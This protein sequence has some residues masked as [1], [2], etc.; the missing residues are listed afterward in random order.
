MGGANQCLTPAA[1]ARAAPPRSPA[2]GAGRAIED[3]ACRTA[4]CAKDTHNGNQGRKGS[5]MSSPID[6]EM[7]AG[8]GVLLFIFGVVLAVIVLLVKL[9]TPT[10]FY[11]ITL[12]DG[13]SIIAEEIGTGCN[14][15]KI[16]REKGTDTE[17]TLLP[18]FRA[19]KL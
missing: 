7:N 17:Y 11:E 13:T 14:G 8:C 4:R 12:S 15:E 5:E 19:K 2:A 3:C 16:Y 18:P 1:P 9:F 10:T 6:D